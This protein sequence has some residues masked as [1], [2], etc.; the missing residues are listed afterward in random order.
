MPKIILAVNVTVARKN[1]HS[2]N[3]SPDFAGNSVLNVLGGFL[4]KRHLPFQS[5]DAVAV[6]LDCK[7]AS[8]L[9]FIS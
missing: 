9:P 7:L 6:T 3:T 4:P 1:G 2:S 5:L 8:F